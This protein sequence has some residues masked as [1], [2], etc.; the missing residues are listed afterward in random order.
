MLIDNSDNDFVGIEEKDRT[1]KQAAIRA[2]E[3]KWVEVRSSHLV[4]AYRLVR[5]PAP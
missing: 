2:F 5:K 4:T 3:D 1:D